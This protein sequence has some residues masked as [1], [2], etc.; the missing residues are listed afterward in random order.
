[1]TP[2]PTGFRS[3]NI[4][5]RRRRLAFWESLRHPRGS[6]PCRRVWCLIAM[7]VVILIIAVV[8]LVVGAGLWKLMPWAWMAAVVVVA[9]GAIWRSQPD[10]RIRQGQISYPY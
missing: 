7:V 5:D 6:Q 8:Q 4:D 2:R 1:M 9:I 10:R 3:S